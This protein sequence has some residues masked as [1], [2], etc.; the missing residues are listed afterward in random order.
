[1]LRLAFA[2]RFQSIAFFLFTSQTLRFFYFQWCSHSF[3]L[4]HLLLAL[5]HYTDTFF[6]RLCDSVHWTYTRDRLIALCIRYMHIL[7]FI[8]SRS[9]VNIFYESVWIRKY[10]EFIRLYIIVVAFVRLF[11]RSLV[12]SIVSMNSVSFILCQCYGLCLSV[13]ECCTNANFS[14]YIFSNGFSC[15][16]SLSPNALLSPRRLEPNRTPKQPWVSIHP[17]MWYVMPFRAIY[18]GLQ[19]STTRW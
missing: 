17:S 1:M 7:I 16:Y 5:I 11:P 19:Y 12:H 3:W 4:T 18:Y 6:M 2:P 14:S 8:V 15:S 10:S 13:L 9:I